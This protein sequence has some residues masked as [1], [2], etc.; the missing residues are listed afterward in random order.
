MFSSKK[1]NKVYNKS[2]HYYILFQ[3]PISMMK[4]VIVTCVYFSYF[5][6]SK[7][8]FESIIGSSNPK[9]AN[10]TGVVG[11]FRGKSYINGTATTFQDLSKMTVI[12]FEYLKN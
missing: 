9:Y 3:Y 6:N 4:L 8:I 12:T 11:K 2:L 10:F 7:I 5:A 1:Y